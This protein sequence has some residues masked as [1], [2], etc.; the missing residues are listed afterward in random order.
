MILPEKQRLSG[1]WKPDL[2]IAYKGDAAFKKALSIAREM[3]R[4]QQVCYVDFSA[5]SLK[6]QMRQANK[7]EAAHVLI[8]GEDELARDFYTIKRMDDSRQ[9]EVTLEELSQ[10]LQSNAPSGKNR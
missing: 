5:G 8:I 7:M 2:F 10:Y 6:S 4:L 1:I 3:R 9:W